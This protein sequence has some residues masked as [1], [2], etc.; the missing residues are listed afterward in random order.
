MTGLL[1]D[2][3]AVLRARL[4]LAYLYKVLS[5]HA[6]RGALQLGT[7]ATAFAVTHH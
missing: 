6:L 5:R 2:Q 1:R 3:S 7:L 4:F